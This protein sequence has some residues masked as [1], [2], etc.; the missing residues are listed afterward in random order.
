MLRTPPSTREFRRLKATGAQPGRPTEG[1]PTTPPSPAPQPRLTAAQKRQRPSHKYQKLCLII[2]FK[3][4]QGKNCKLKL[5]ELTSSFDFFDVCQTNKTEKRDSALFTD[6]QNGLEEGA[7]PRGRAEVRS[8]LP[9]R[10]PRGC[11]L[12]PASKA[13]GSR[14]AG[15]VQLLQPRP[16]TGSP[17]LLR[18][19]QKQV[20]DAF[21]FF[22]GINIVSS[23]RGVAERL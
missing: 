4:K 14:G 23:S 10:L 5:Q 19:T 1:F 12:V 3:Q 16:P 6:V 20:G 21:C 9:P 2:R 15:Q 11:V 8:G 22:L 7:V 13:R 18:N 17:V